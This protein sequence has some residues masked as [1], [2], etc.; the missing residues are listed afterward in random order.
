MKTILKFFLHSFVDTWKYYEINSLYLYNT[1]VNIHFCWESLCICEKYN[2]ENDK[3]M[4][5]WFGCACVCEEKRGGGGKAM[6]DFVN[7]W[8]IL[9]AS[10][11]N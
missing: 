2:F 9:D 10:E 1:H 3:E 8:F 11:N 5:I 7:K 4:P 6:G